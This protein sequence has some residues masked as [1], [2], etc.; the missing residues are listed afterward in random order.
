M[1]AR[2][3]IALSLSLL[4]SFLPH[5][6][7]FP[8][9]RSVV[10]ALSLPFTIFPFLFLFW[11]NFKRRKNLFLLDEENLFWLTNKLFALSLSLSLSLST[12]ALITFLVG[13]YW[14]GTKNK[15]VLFS[16]LLASRC[17][18]ANFERKAWQKMHGDKEWE[19]KIMTTKER[20]NDKR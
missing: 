3:L 19:M 5:D 1:T 18:A 2:A 14:S 16:F 11:T 20:N 8:Q 15:T 7:I 9:S 6:W 12:I 17:V 4:S 10:M 13:N